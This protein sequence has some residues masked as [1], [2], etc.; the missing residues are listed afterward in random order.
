MIEPRIRHQAIEAATGTGL[1]VGRTEDDPGDPAL[2]D[3]ARAHRAGLQGRIER[4]A[5][6]APGT[7]GATGQR[8]GQ[9]FGMSRWI[10]QGLPQI[11]GLREDLAVAHHDRAHG[12]LSQRQRLASQSQRQ[13]HHREVQR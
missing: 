12:D 8:Q 2:D 3:R 10:I 5:F 6:Q 7:Q 4:A 11:V 1:G 13:A 9:S